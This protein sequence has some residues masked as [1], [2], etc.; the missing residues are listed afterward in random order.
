M[1][2][3]LIVV[4]GL[5]CALPVLAQSSPGAGEILIDATG[6]D[7]H[8]G[9]SIR[10]PLPPEGPQRQAFLKEFIRVIPR[11]NEAHL[12][13]RT[14]SA[15]EFYN[16]V[17]RS[18]LAAQADDRTRQRVWLISGSLLVLAAGA[19]G[20][21]VVLSN[22]QDV[23]DPVCFVHGNFSYNQCVDRHQ[24]TLI[25]G[26]AIIAATVVVA[27]GLFTWGVLTQ[28]MVT[29]PDETV[30]LAVGYNRSLAQKHGAT[31]ARLRLVPALAP[32]YAGLTARLSF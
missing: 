4:A 31:G 26:T 13:E 11:D 8:H 20:G 24:Q 5:G 9:D 27:G 28:E 25:I 12:G 3:G 10:V 17:G 21:A 19:A 14:L 23:N 6:P 1:V 29:T 2:R 32:G 15:F 18:D 22:A 30:R 16:R 7:A